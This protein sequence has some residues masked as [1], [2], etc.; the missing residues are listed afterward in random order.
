MIQLVQAHM[1]VINVGMPIIIIIISIYMYNNIQ[2]K[3]QVC[4]LNVIPRIRTK[5]CIAVTARVY[6]GGAS[7]GVRLYRS[8]TT[9][10]SVGYELS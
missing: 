9:V 1:R 6:K 8:D 4:K 2:R 5:R 3:I 7:Y 10:L